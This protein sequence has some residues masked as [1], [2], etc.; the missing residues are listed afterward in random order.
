MNTSHMHTINAL[1]VNDIFLHNQNSYWI[2]TV[3]QPRL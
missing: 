2:Q 1:H 3:Y